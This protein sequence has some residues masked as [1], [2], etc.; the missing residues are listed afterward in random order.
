[1]LYEWS[2][3]E[4]NEQMSATMHEAHFAIFIGHYKF[5]ATAT[6]AVIVEKIIRDMAVSVQ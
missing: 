6:M 2:L 1:M 3:Q 4:P 5:V